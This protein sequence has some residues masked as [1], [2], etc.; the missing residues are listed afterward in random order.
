[1]SRLNLRLNHSRR[2]AKFCGSRAIFDVPHW[3]IEN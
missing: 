3:R 2:S 1:V